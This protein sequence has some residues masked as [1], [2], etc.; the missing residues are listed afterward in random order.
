MASRGPSGNNHFFES[1]E[2]SADHFTHGDQED[3]R[4]DRPEQVVSGRPLRLAK[5]SRLNTPAN[6]P[7]NDWPSISNRRPDHDRAGCFYNS[8]P[9]ETCL[10]RLA[11]GQFAAL[12]VV[13]ITTSHWLSSHPADRLTW[14]TWSPATQ[15]RTDN[16][17][18]RS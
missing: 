9:A 16:L 4:S 14:P 13:V 10:R 18:S 11:A 1:P 5:C 12:V 6:W 15:R 17:V 2:D 3:L 7:L 8:T